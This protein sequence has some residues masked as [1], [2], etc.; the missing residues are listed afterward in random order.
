VC[1]VLPRQTCG[2][3]THTIFRR[4]Y[5]GGFGKLLHTI[6][7]GELFETIVHN[8]VNIYMTHMSNYANDRLALFTFKTLFEFVQEHTNLRLKYSKPDT[9]VD[10][11]TGGLKQ[12]GGPAFLADYYFSLHPEE[13]EPLWT[14]SELWH[15]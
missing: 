8:P 1:Q 11:E 9:V 15:T 12:V 6:R 2:L 13:R 7:G 3:Y 14:V 4:K 5:P 10:E